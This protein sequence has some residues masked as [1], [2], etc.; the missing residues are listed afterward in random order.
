MTTDAVTARLLDFSQDPKAYVEYLDSVVTTF[1]STSDK[2]QV[3]DQ[4][5]QLDVCLGRPASS[6]YVSN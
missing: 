4:L 1:Y 2:A 6:A 5:R 3:C